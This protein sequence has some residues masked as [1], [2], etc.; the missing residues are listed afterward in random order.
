MAKQNFKLEKK[1]F[2]NKKIT[3]QLSLN[4]EKLAK[5]EVPINL[6]RIKEIYDEIFYSIPIDG[7]ESHKNLVEQEYNYLY[8]DN[9]L[10]LEKKI[11]NL[12]EKIQ[13]KTTELDSLEITEFNKKEHPLYENSS[14]L[15]Q[16]ANGS[17]LQ[18]AVYVWIMQEGRKR[19][20][21]SQSDPV[22]LEVKKSLN[23]PKG[24]LDGR[25][26]V[27]T[28]D[29]NSIPDGRPITTTRDLNLKGSSLIPTQ[30]LAD[31]EVRH[32]YHTVE[33][34]CLGNEVADFSTQVI[35]GE[36]DTSQLQ[37]YLGSNG[38]TIRYFKDDSSTD[39]ISLSIETIYINRG[40]TITLDILREGLGPEDNGIPNN[41]NDYYTAVG[42][43][44]LANQ[45]YYGNEISDYI[46]NWGPF[47]EYEGIL[48]ATGRLKIKQLPNPYIQDVLLIPQDTS[49]IVLNGLPE[50][51]VT[52][53][54][55]TIIQPGTNSSYTG[56][57]RSI[58]DT[59]M[60]YKGQ[61]LWG[62]LNQNNELQSQVFDSPNNKYY[63]K[64][65]NV[66]EGIGNV[67]IYGQPILRYM[68]TYCVLL[69]GFSENLTRK[70]RFLDLVSGNKFTRRRGQ[71]E[72]DLNWQMITSSGLG[73]LGMKWDSEKLKGRIVDQGYVG[74]QEYKTNM[75]EGQSNYFN[76]DTTGNN[77]S[78]PFPGV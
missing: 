40:E 3:E 66:D 33:I 1:V 8:K 11:K 45:D 70:L 10:R 16:G 62:S 20:F 18:D 13:A 73:I 71:V 17:P 55:I 5:S 72:D 49:Q 4:F 67:L 59:K 65:M 28:E 27:S 31:I 61:N 60:I 35:N 14:I 19:R 51:T 24:Q 44:S 36:V 74:L 9:N 34:E 25:Y 41:K 47:G 56:Q 30:E 58:Y 64:T 78:W 38:C 63:K 50:T 42:A 7:K 53:E 12:I 68:S 76:P 15:Q 39:E 21:E 77:Y 29:L 46:K 6:K 2:S 69:G 32:A 48:Y 26:Y 37:F 75:Y 22:F 43:Y 23:L 54:P 52:G 57:E